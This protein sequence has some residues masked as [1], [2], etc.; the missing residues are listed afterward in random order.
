MQKLIVTSFLAVAAPLA[1]ADTILGIF[2]GVGTWNSDYSGDTGTISADL[3]D[4]GLTEEHNKFFY[5]ALEHPVPILPNVKLQRTNITSKETGTLD[6]NFRLDEV[7]FGQGESVTTDLDLSHTD[8]ILYYELLDNWVNL[9]LGVTL[10][11]FDGQAEARAEINGTV[12]SESVELDAV[13][14]MLYA[15]A[16]FD[17]PLTGFSIGADAH[18]TGY[19]GSTLTDISAKV[20]YAFESVVDLGVELGYRRFALELDD[21]DDLEADVALDGPYAAVTL[22]F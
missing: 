13:V 14:P 5:V 15:R 3:D 16:Q 20:A 18:V 8:A 10:R 11:S 2:A 9:D 4:L 6:G 22:H 12:V 1:Q 21:L 7:T 19:S 17:L